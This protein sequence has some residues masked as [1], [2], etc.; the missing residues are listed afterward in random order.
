MYDVSACKIDGTYDRSQKTALTPDHM[1]Q[2]IIDDQRPERDKDQ[3]C[4]EVHTARHRSGNQSRSDDREHHLER[5][6][7]Q[8]RYGC[9]IGSCLKCNAVQAKPLERTDESAVVAAEA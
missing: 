9:R 1:G 8:V 5:D 4:L 3:E 2:R 7:G 6:E